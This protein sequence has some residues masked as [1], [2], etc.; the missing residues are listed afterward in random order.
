MPRKIKGVEYYSTA[1]VCEAA[2]VTRQTL[3]RWR[4]E[5]LAPSGHRFRNNQVLFTAAEFGEVLAHAHRVEPTD[6]DTDP[7][8]LPLRLGH[9]R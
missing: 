8:Q 2:G 6:S 9:G 5:G 3:W 4:Q 7:A 1:E